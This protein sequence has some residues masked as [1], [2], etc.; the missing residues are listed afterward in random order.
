MIPWS[1]ARGKCRADI[2]VGVES[3]RSREGSRRMDRARV[4]GHASG[5]EE[6]RRPGGESRGRR[7]D[8]LRDRPR[9]RSLSP[10]G[11]PMGRSSGLG[12]GARPRGPRSKARATDGGR[13]DRRAHRGR[14]R[15][16][17]DA[18]G[19]MSSRSCR[20]SRGP[21]LG[22]RVGR[23]RPGRARRARAGRARRRRL[24]RWRIA[25]C[26]G[27]PCG[28]PPHGVPGRR[29]AVAPRSSGAES[30]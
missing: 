22:V 6:R 10:R 1:G 3:E 30:I 21:W 9:S 20:A 13:Q 7:G 17:A 4:G 29:G 14:P 27:R 11:Q 19:P 16:R 15:P 2:H 18:W 28:G 23:P 26:R 5:A 12:W 8:K 24:R 25:R